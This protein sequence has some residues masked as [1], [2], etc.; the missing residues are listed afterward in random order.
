VLVAAVL[1]AALATPAGATWSIVATEPESGEVGVAIASCVP[2]D[3]LG[4]TDQPLVPVILVPGHAAAVTQGQL[5]LDAPARVG[6]LAAA[7]AS[8]PD[9]IAELTAA[10]FDE[11]A[12][13]R[14]HAVVDLSGGAAAFTG[15]ATSPEALDRQGE[16]VSVQGNLLASPAV[17]TDSLA[18][19]QASRDAGQDLATALVAGLLAGS[20]A[21]GDRRCGQQTALFAQVAVAG[22][23]DDQRRP[24]TLLTVLVDEG[25]GQNPVELLASSLAGGAEGT[26]DL[27]AAEA[28]GGGLVRAAVGAV[29]VM[30]VGVGWFVFRRGLGSRQ[31]RR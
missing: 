12:D 3:A 2:G 26:T 5:N 21:G 10:D 7:D 14:Q 18:R 25:D 17:V 15:P 20:E 11:L 22:R 29:S 16:N 31:A 23:D 13:Q 24:S 27:G 28:S 9:I 1:L 8:P 6:Q 30:M 19:F 4:S